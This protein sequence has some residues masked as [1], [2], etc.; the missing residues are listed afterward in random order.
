MECWLNKQAKQQ[1]RI[2]QQ[3][4]R[5]LAKDERDAKR[6]LRVF[7]LGNG[8]SGKS[9]LI[10]QMRI[11]HSEGYSREHNKVFISHEYVQNCL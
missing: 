5:Q 10:R 6:E 9:A 2:S 3:I 7:L 4:E 8:Q 1:K 11:I